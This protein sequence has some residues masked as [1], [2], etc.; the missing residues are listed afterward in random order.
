MRDDNQDNNDSNDD[1]DDPEELYYDFDDVFIASSCVGWW[2]I[3]PLL[4]A[5]F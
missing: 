1:D 5:T 3:F 2:N 4:V